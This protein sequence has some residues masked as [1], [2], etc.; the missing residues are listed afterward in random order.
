[1][2]DDTRS[3]RTLGRVP[4]TPSRTRPCER[5]FAVVPAVL[6]DISTPEAVERAAVR[7][8]AESRRARLR[9]R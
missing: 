3:T 1:M 4:P 7:C 2:S 9:L 6:G 5:M 8:G